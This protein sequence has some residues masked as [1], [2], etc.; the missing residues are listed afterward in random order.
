MIN[1]IVSIQRIDVVTHNVLRFKLTKSK[2]ISFIPGQAAEVAIYQENW[3]EKNRPFTFTSLPSDDYIE[4][5]IK[6][7]PDHQGVTNKLSTLKVNDQLIIKD[8]FG[9]I[10]YQGDGTFIA[11]GAGV[12]PFISI[13]RDLNQKGKIQGNTL[14]F[15]NKTKKDIIN[16]YEFETMLHDNFKNILSNEKAVGYDYG[17]IDSKY[18]RDHINLNDKHYYV[19]GPKPMMQAVITSLKA[20]GIKESN[21]VKEKF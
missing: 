9:A 6:I 18:L 19:C 2:D 3:K 14:L 17:H 10:H 15:A 5:T 21:I 1:Q 12:T 8:I 7:Y 20:L 11:G 16:A 4:F 13:L